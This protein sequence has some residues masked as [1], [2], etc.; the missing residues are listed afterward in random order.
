MNVRI[1]C[2]SRYG[3]T[4]LIGEWIGERLSLGGHQVDVQEAASAGPPE[5]ADLVVLGSG[6]YADKFLPE[7][8]AYIEQHADALG[9][10]AVALFGVALQRAP[11]IHKGRLH[12]GLTYLLPYVEM[13]RTPPIHAD[14]LLGEL[15]PQKLSD[16]DRGDLLRFYAMIGLNEA[17]TRQRMAPRSLM[18]KQECWGFA[19]ALMGKAL[20]AA[21]KHDGESADGNKVHGAEA[22]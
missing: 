21:K 8:K 6:I 1:V 7:L 22:S 13:L 20:Q 11:M 4:R 19:E 5:G 17:Q 9:E 2:A 14:I 10:R 3:S 16:K 15:I 12:G 18:S